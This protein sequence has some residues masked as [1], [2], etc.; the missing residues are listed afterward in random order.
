MDL[1]NLLRREPVRGFRLHGG[2]S[3]VPRRSRRGGARSGGGPPR[4]G[5]SACLLP[6]VAGAAFAILFVLANPDL[7][8][9]VD[10]WLSNVSLP[11]G[12][13]AAVD[14]PSPGQG[15]LCTLVAGL[16]LGA[17]RPLVRALAARSVGEAGSRPRLIAGGRRGPR[18]SV[19]YSAVRNTLYVVVAL[20]AAYLP[21]EFLTL[22][23]RDFPDGF[24]YAG[25]AHEG[26][27][28]LTAALAAATALLSAMIRGSLLT[29]PRLGRVR[30]LAWVWSGLNFLLVAAVLQPAADLRRLQRPCPGCGWSAS[31]ASPRW[32]MGFAA[33]WW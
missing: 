10:A 15:F 3:H 26:A 5:S 30:T 1:R 29:D 2:G 22:W 32:R 18:P 28:W 33:W 17:L 20:F 11:P 31:S 16:T 27:A 25:Y 4:D 13:G 9:T 23:R 24:Y 6:I 8:S 7:R 19:A 12:R 21:F 14:L